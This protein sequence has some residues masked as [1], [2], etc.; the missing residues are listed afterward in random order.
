MVH[1]HGK[2]DFVLRIDAGYSSLARRGAAISDKSPTS[3]I[4]RRRFE[5]TL[6]IAGYHSTGVPQPDAKRRDAAKRLF[7]W[8]AECYTSPSCRE[9]LDTGKIEG[10]WRPL[11][12]SSP[13][14]ILKGRVNRLAY[15]R[16]FV[17]GQLFHE[18]SVVGPD[19][20]QH[21]LREVFCTSRLLELLK[22]PGRKEIYVWNRHVFAIKDN[23][24][25]TEDVEG[26][27]SSFLY[28]DR[29][30][31]LFLTA[32]IMLLP[33]AAWVLIRKLKEVRSLPKV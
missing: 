5:T 11:R 26:V 16:T 1:R 31:L 22:A 14:L 28:R 9:M 29:Y 3:A 20:D 7:R 15:S 32:S 19:G 23:G 8:R 12:T 17:D 27:R 30:L 18:L 4:P 10:G 13:I 24:R 6:T 25:L 2:V 33:Y 21:A